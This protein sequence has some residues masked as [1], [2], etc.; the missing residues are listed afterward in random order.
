MKKIL[1]TAATLLL[2]FG[3]VALSTNVAA[4]DDA[5]ANTAAVVETA[6][7]ETI[8][9]EQSEPALAEP[10]P[11]VE[12]AVQVTATEIV[13]ADPVVEQE[14]VVAEESPAPAESSS[15]V[16]TQAV[17]EANVGIIGELYPNTSDS[18]KAS[19]WEDFGPHDDAICYKHEGT[20]G[21]GHGS[22]TNG[23]K[24]VVLN[25][26][27]ADWPGDHWE[28]LVVKAGNW[29]AVT[30]HP[31]AGVE[32]AAPDY[33]E[34]S[35]WIV[36]KGTTPEEPVVA[37]AD[38]EVKPA[39]CDADGY[40]VGVNP[41][42]ATF[43]TP[44]YENGQ[45]TI[46]A[47][48]T[49][50]ATFPAGPGVSPD[51]KTKTFTGP[52]AEQLGDDE[53]LA[54]AA[55][56]VDPAT[57]GAAGYVTGTGTVNATFGT[58]TYENGQYTIVA[59]ATGDAKFAAGEGVSPDGKTKTF[60][61]SYEPQ[62]S[63]AECVASASVL[64]KPATCAADGS[65]VSDAAV[66][67]T[68]GEPIYENGQYTIVATATGAAKFAA[69]EGVSPDGKT[70]TFTGS[71]D[72]KLTGDECDLPTHDLVVPTISFTQPTCVAN[73]TYTVGGADV[74]WSRNGTPIDNGKYSLASGVEIELTVAPKPPHGFSPDQQKSWK[75]SFKAP[76]GPCDL[77]TLALTGADGDQ[78]VP[79]AIAGFA[80]LLG[81]AAVHRA[82]RT[83]AVR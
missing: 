19:Y 44:T 51:G 46:V 6:A 30:I 57:C 50:E 38:V 59:T 35:H 22:V 31:V 53:C 65:V 66:N 76:S 16:A 17:L 28:L 9:P 8:A 13:V 78:T 74:Q 43:G 48:A 10:A 80:V 68:F 1:A 79:L 2:A 20:N 4:A 83:K 11:V 56:V 27:G 3:S 77:T 23:G 64:V 18:N 67:A 32:Y 71:Y 54:S 63:E 42:N 49:G 69:G 81:L 47:T 21:G 36:C 70:K 40:V 14:P 29:D 37:S 39:T 41:V 26:Y 24:T 73:G 72:A 82:R 34:V 5:A 33:K 45:Y 58:P 62:L 15:R 52:Y 55:V 25:P 61:G 60:T 12:A 75:V 7:V